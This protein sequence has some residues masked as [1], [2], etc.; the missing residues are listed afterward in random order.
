[1]TERETSATPS[2]DTPTTEYEPT[3]DEIALQAYL[4]WEE[5]GCEGGS[6]EEDWLR[7]EQELRSRVE[8]AVTA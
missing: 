4:Y 7:A 8:K 2:V 6:S 5:R 3:R 1:V